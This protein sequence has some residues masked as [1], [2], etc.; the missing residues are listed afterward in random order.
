MYEGAGAFSVAIRLRLVDGVS[1]GIIG[2]SRHFAKGNLEAKALQSRLDGIKRT[3]VI[4]AG[5]TIAGGGML[6]L[7]ESTLPAAKEYA[8]QLSLMNTLGMRQADVA[9]VVGAA[10]KTTFDVPTT[11]ITENLKSFRELR[12]VFGVG[13]EAEAAATLPLVG[14]IQGILTALTGKEQERVGFDLVKAIELRQ[15]GVMTQAFLN[16]NSNM[17]AQTLI[18]MGGTLSVGDFHGALKM[19]KANTADWSDDFVYKYLPTLMQE[20]K[21]GAGGAQSAGTYLSTFSRAIHGHMQKAA[22]PLWI[23]SGLVAAS[24]VVKNATGQYQMKPGSVRDTKLFEE[25]PFAWVQK[26]LRPAVMAIMAKDHISLKSAVDG[27]FSDRNAA[28]TAFNMLTKAQQ[29]ERDKQTVQGADSINAYQKLLKTNPELA[30]MALQK[31][32]TNIKAQIGFTLM[33]DLLR[34][35]SNL[36]PQLTRLSEWINKNPGAVGAWVKGFAAV[37]ALLTVAGGVTLTAGFVQSFQ[38]LFDI[39]KAAKVKALAADTGVLTRLFP[40]IGGAVEGLAGA[41]GLSVGALAGTVAIGVAAAAAIGF[42]VYEIAKHWTAGK[43]I[44]WNVRHELTEFQSWVTGWS[45]KAIALLPKPIQAPVRAV[46]GQLTF[47]LADGTFMERLRLISSAVAP[48]LAK[49]GAIADGLSGHVR[50]WL[51]FGGKLT[52]AFGRVYGAITGFLDRIVALPGQWIAAHVPHLPGLPKPAG[53]QGGGRPLAPGAKPAGRPLGNI[54]GAAI[55]KAVLGMIPGYGQLAALPSP[56]K[57]RSA[58][59]RAKFLDAPKSAGAWLDSILPSKAQ[60]HAAGQ[61]VSKGVAGGIVAAHPAVRAAAA[62]TATQAVVA[63]KAAADIH[64]PSRVFA[65]L[66]DQLIMGLIVGVDR[67]AP[68]L[69]KRIS[70]LAGRMAAPF[71]D[72]TTTFGAGPLGLSL[73]N[74][75]NLRRWGDA[76]RVHGFAAF[77]SAVDGLHAMGRQLQLYS[78]RGLNTVSS[79]V[80]RWAPSSENATGAYIAAVSRATG[81]AANQRLNLNDTRQLSTLM[82]AMIRRE[83]GRSPYTL[84]QIAAAVAGTPTRSPYV[85][86]RG[87]HVTV[88]TKTMLDGRVLT[89]T[90]TRH[91]AHDASRPHAGTSTFDP[92]MSAAPVGLGYHP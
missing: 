87:T 23:Q 19:G 72:S 20:L 13:H 60:A 55:G 15:K 39:F 69:M 52:G 48:F 51:D 64:S 27:M 53:A 90:V 78:A 68:G 58:L 32:W 28:F 82:G 26:D 18:G 86:T 17:M 3:M 73:N 36:I 38:L 14:K 2:L 22:M 11:S 31:Q 89:E 37:G 21:T 47:G 46:A 30:E 76:A 1:A 43:S 42:T 62:G 8:N 56:D 79:I 54:V 35:A 41:L 34:L 84:D 66:G 10:W 40:A 57:I 24:D 83:Q 25:N 29:Y 74:P 91:Q 85:Q 5:L 70:D 4:G 80:G 45:N 49:L 61:D 75:G 65:G 63:F 33:P 12:S 16:A 88:H 7:V 6:K 44:F 81:F 71:R 77:H 92:T 9:R 67:S 59:A 50:S